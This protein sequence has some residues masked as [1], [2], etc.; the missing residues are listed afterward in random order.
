MWTLSPICHFHQYIL[1][2]LIYD[3]LG[4]AG[5]RP[6]NHF[7][8]QPVYSGQ[9]SNYDLSS[10]NVWLTHLMSRYCG[11]HGII[12][13]SQNHW[14]TH[15]AVRELG[16]W[17]RPPAPTGNDTMVGSKQTLVQLLLKL[18]DS[19]KQIQLNLCA[20]TFTLTIPSPF[21]FYACWNDSMPL[22]FPW[23]TEKERELLCNYLVHSEKKTTNCMLH[24]CLIRQFS[25]RGMRCV[26]WVQKHQENRD[27]HFNFNWPQLCINHSLLCQHLQRW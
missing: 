22:Y 8:P 15:W 18:V 4:F 19:S 21:A 12:I 6:L 13:P 16:L 24:K 9:L 1:C 27:V 17:S 7:Q 10:I 11:Q 25:T 2:G 3:F 20:W 14:N 5:A 23:A 26:P